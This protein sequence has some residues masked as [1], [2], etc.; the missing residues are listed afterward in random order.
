MRHFR[1]GYLLIL[2]SPALSFV[3]LL[4]IV[5][6]AGITLA[7]SGTGS[8]VF[9]LSM[10]LTVWNTIVITF[11]ISG[12]ALY[13]HGY[14]KREATK[15]EAILN[16]VFSF[17]LMFWGTLSY[18]IASGLYGETISRGMN[19]QMTPLTIWDQAQYWTW[20]LK[21]LLWVASGLV[22]TA[23]SFV[24]LSVLRNPEK[25]QSSTTAI[26]PTPEE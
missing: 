26:F 2:L 15:G 9:Q 5:L 8:E 23:T 13:T 21:G 3:V 7:L 10:L 12:L 17:F 19:P 16:F 18:I 20:E 25:Q 22:L 6:F 24:A 4:G 11:L 14:M 1:V